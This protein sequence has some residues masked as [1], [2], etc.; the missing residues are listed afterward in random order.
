LKIFPIILDDKHNGFTAL[1]YEMTDDE[2]EMKKK[3]NRSL[4]F[5]NPV[6]IKH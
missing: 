5:I 3:A 4:G 6:N 2:F 1:P